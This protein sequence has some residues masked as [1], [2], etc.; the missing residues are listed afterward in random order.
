MLRLSQQEKAKARFD[1]NILGAADTFD[2]AFL[3]LGYSLTSTY[4]LEQ[5]HSYLKMR[6]EITFTDY[7]HTPDKSYW[8]ANSSLIYQRKYHQRVEV[9][10][11][12][13]NRYYLRDYKNRDISSIEY[14]NC[15]FTDQSATV[16]GTMPITS[17]LWL[18]GGFGLTK[19]YYNSA[20][21]EFD[22]DIYTTRIRATMRPVR[23]FQTALE[24]SR[25][26]AQNITYL[27][28]ARSSDFDRTYSSRE[29]Y[30]P[31][32]IRPG[33]FLFQRIGFSFRQE[34]RS[35][36]AEALDDPVHAG[37]NHIDRK[38]DFW[39]QENITDDIDVTFNIRYRTRQTKSDYA[40]VGELK[41][42]NQWQSRITI[43]KGFIYDRY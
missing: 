16:S 9:K 30:I 12:H 37:R 7:T 22:L 39:L 2:S 21:A 19:R 25:S 31:I 17:L 41:S 14:A 5:R 18:K 43:T 36:I 15:F 23:W 28:T 35:Y 6:G 42:F 3:R 34:N 10:F 33:S 29:V 38:L 4:R 27:K 13:L 32:I 11:R 20:F 40:W 24:Y 26:R 1:E 8:S